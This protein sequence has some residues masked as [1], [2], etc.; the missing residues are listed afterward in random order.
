M[1]SMYPGVFSGIGEFSIYKEAVSGKI[2]GKTATLKDPAL[3]VIL[4]TAA[5]IELIS[6]KLFYPLTMVCKDRNKTSQLRRN[7]RCKI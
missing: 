2:Y 1:I 4:D 6:S 5:E 3:D 7:Q